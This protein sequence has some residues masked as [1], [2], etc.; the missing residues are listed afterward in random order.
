M[1]KKIDSKLINL[2][3]LENCKDIANKSKEQIEF[4]KQR[5]LK[6]SQLTDE[7]KERMLIELQECENK[8]TQKESVGK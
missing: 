4:H 2:L 7:E 6:D 8:L 1:G 5:I 3:G